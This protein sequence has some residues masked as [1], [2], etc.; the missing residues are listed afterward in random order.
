MIC[1][2]DGTT[3]SQP[4]FTTRWTLVFIPFQLK[5]DTRLMI[6][7]LIAMGEQCWVPLPLCIPSSAP[8]IETVA[9]LL[10]ILIV[11]G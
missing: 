6:A 5:K 4:T 8:F 10:D 11:V 7:F 1:L 9:L 3:P 2:A